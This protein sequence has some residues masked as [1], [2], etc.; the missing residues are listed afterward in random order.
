MASVIEETAAGL[1]AAPPVSIAPPN[2]ARWS[3]L[4]SVAVRFAVVFLVVYTGAR[5]LNAGALPSLAAAVMLALCFLGTRRMFQRTLPLPLGLNPSFPSLG[6]TVLLLLAV[7]RLAL[8][9]GGLGI[10]LFISAVLVFGITVLEC[11]V[12]PPAR[13]RRVLVVGASH[14]SEQ[15]AR[16]L[17]R[18]S[19]LPF[20]VIGIVDDCVV[21]DDGLS[22]RRGIDELA[23]IVV[24]SRPDLIVLA[25]DAEQ[26]TVLQELLDVAAVGFRVIPIH[27][28]HEYAFGRVPVD[29]L[30]SAWF[31]SVLH[32]YQRTYSRLSKRAFDLVIL[33]VALP[34]LALLVPLMALLVRLS[35]AGP[36]LFRQIRVGEHG[37]PF[38]MIKFRT[39]V[40]GA[41]AP[42]R[43]VWAG[44]GDPR[45]TPIG[46]LMRR[47]RLDELPQL[48]NVLCGDMSIVGPRP[49]RPEFLE[50]LE[51]EVP[52]WSR[53][54]LVKPG[55]T[56]W[57]QVRH[58]YTADV[59]GAAEKL[60]Y[61]LYYLKHRSLRLD[62]AIVAMTALTVA[63]GFGS[64]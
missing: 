4:R 15:L 11:V 63:G 28:F 29:L 1:R 20:D 50:L 6:V 25:D 52:F 54:H 26:E 22:A 14:R 53:R 21:V 13:R 34:V 47:M 2:R 46:R 42:G 27:Q 32:L 60:S 38:Q 31:M 30:S 36:V 44:E 43:A 57:A 48:W 59:A 23:E 19:A 7:A 17:E 64:R 45:I 24:E 5:W 9:A 56:G 41:E 55:L 58:P 3:W 16:D 39:M 61:D 12:E 8:G 18:Q 33:T 37:E 51:D 35:S 62:L 10:P 40:D 49:E